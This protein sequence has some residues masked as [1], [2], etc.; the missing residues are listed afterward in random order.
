MINGYDDA[1]PFVPGIDIGMCLDNLFERIVPVDDRFERSR[2]SQLFDVKQILRALSCGPR[3][4]FLA[5]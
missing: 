1:S 5:A 4:D 3:K 2:L